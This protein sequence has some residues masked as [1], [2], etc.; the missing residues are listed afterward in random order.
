M[1]GAFAGD[2]S[3]NPVN[4]SA[5]DYLRACDRSTLVDAIAAAVSDG[6]AVL[7]ALTRDHGAV[8]VT[9][10]DGDKRHKAYANNQEEFDGLVGDLAASFAGGNDTPPNSPV[11]ASRKR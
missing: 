1:R 10:L 5:S 2:T 9:V 8:V 4:R 3:V 11:K 7:F 6:V